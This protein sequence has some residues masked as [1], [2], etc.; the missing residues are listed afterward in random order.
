M[1]EFLKAPFLFLHFTYCSND[2][3]NDVICNITIYADDTN[4]KCDL[5]L[6]NN[7]KWLLNLNLIC[8]TVWTRARSGIFISMLEKLNWFCLTSLI[9]LVL[10]EEKSSFK[11][12]GLTFSSKLDQCFA[13]KKIGALICSVKFLLP[14]VALYLCKSSI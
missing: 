1:L 4:L 10:F 3:T 14:K 2:L 9:T 7:Q 13:S 5:I 12:L 11:M 8:K 6:G